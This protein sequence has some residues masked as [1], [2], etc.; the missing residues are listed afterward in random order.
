LVYVAAV[1]ATL[2]LLLPTLV[3]AANESSSIDFGHAKRELQRYAYFT[4]PTTDCPHRTYACRRLSPRRVACDSEILVVKEG[5]IEPQH[6]FVVE[7]QI[8][9]WVGVA[10][11][12]H[13]STK[14]LRLAA[15]HFKCR[16]AKPGEG[17]G[18]RSN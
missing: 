6:K 9:S 12:F 5:V 4:C 18:G 15:K 1:I 17:L 7:R 8:C 2:A 11:P 10:T 14:K 3:S 13:G 16:L